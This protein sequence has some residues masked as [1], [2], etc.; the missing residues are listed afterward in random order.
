MTDWDKYLPQMVG[1][2]NSTQH[3]TTGI[4]PFMMLTGRE[5]ERERERAMPLTFFYPEYKGKKMSPQAYVKEAVRRQEEWNEL[6]RRNTAQAQMRQRK[7]HDEKILQ[8]KPYAVGQYVWVFQNV[9]PAK[10]T[11]KLLKKWRGLF[12]ISEVHQQGRSY[13]LI[14]G[15]AAHYESMRCNRYGDDFLI[16]KIQ[17]EEIGEDSVNI[18]DLV[19]DEER[20]IIYDSEHSFQEDYSVPEREIEQSEIVRGKI[21]I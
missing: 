20:Q 14:T 1:A 19:A 9:I 7:T 17:P 11:K 4:S 18:G 16:D 3:S 6:C 15:R 21:Q 12:R 10:G 13:C 2:Y 5:R 8:A